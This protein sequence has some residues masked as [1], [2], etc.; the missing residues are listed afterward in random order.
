MVRR[1]LFGPRPTDRDDLGEGDRAYFADP[2]GPDRPASAAGLLGGFFLRAGQRSIDEIHGSARVER[3]RDTAVECSARQGLPAPSRYPAASC[4]EQPV[5]RD[6]QV[7]PHVPKLRAIEG[8]SAAFSADFSSADQARASYNPCLA[9][10][11]AGDEGEALLI[12][13][14]LALGSGGVG[15]AYVEGVAPSARAMR[16]PGAEFAAAALARDGHAVVAWGRL[17]VGSAA[18][19]AASRL[20]PSLVVSGP[21][22]HDRD[23]ERSGVGLIVIGSSCDPELV[24]LLRQTATVNVAP[25]LIVAAGK[26]R[27]DADVAVRLGPIE[28]HAIARGVLPVGAARRALLGVAAR[29]DGGLPRSP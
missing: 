27:D 13:V 15:V 17:C 12:G 16:V 29:L 25:P 19:V 23:R 11:L 24:G 18:A 1:R 4:V 3:A 28:R 5:V 7:R 6:R 22:N 26:Q 14:G 20:M 9:L 21:E 10:N 2:D 8:G